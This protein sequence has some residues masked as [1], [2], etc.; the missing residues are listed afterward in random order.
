MDFPAQHQRDAIPLPP[1]YDVYAGRRRAIWMARTGGVVTPCLTK[2]QALNDLWKYVL[3]YK[4][5]STTG[6]W[7]RLPPTIRAAHKSAVT[8]LARDTVSAMYADALK[9]GGQS[10]SS[11]FESTSSSAGARVGGACVSDSGALNEYWEKVVNYICNSSTGCW[12]RLPKDI[13]EAH[14]NAMQSTIGK[15]MDYI[16]ADN[17]RF[18]GGS[19]ENPT[20]TDSKT[21][22]VLPCVTESGAIKDYE[23]EVIGYQKFSGRGCFQF[24]PKGVQSAFDTFTGTMKSAVAKKGGGQERIDPAILA[25]ALPPPR[26]AIPCYI[27]HRF[28]KQP[29]SAGWFDSPRTG[30]ASKKKK[31][32]KRRSYY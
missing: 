7:S 6:C 11:D 25:Y 27:D 24:L 3:F 32:R 16:Y 29:L 20:A 13:K 10:S 30:G 12:N 28:D 9:S 19:A 23:E 22:G 5:N 1:Q 17:V 31:Y 21:A 14:A 2:C 8:T 18:I 26:P 4:K 15:M